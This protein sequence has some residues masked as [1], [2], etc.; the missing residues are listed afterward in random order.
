MTMRFA[1]LASN[2]FLSRSDLSVMN[3]YTNQC[4]YYFY[5]K[6]TIV[7]IVI[8]VLF[9]K[10]CSNCMTMSNGGTYSVLCCVV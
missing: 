1:I 2:N 3:S 7:V 10:N 6:E 8:I 9:T 4:N 5:S